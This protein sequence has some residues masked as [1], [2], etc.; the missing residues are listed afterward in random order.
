MEGKAKQRLIVV[1]NRLPF[2]LLEKNKEI[3]LKESDGGLVSAL[4][5]YFDRPERNDTFDSKWWIGSADFPEA[6]W[7]KFVKQS[8][9][10]VSFNVE[11]IFIE[12]KIFNKF[13]NGFCNAT[14]WP[15]F[16]YVPSFVE[17]DEETFK[18]YEAVNRIFADKLLSFLQPNDILWIHD[19]QLMLLPGMIR[20]QRPDATIGFFLHIPF[21]SFEVF[22]MLHRPWK[23]KIV[24]G[25]L[26]ADM[27]GFHTHEYVQHFLKTV[28][29]HFSSRQ[30]CEGGP[31]PAGNRL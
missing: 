19:Y 16:H 28:P 31:V 14:L 12:K 18:S 2:Q 15:L 13:Y 4:K 11:P 8:K 21:P 7:N 20:E 5:S 24:N 6:R 23:E 30:T 25:L 27:I 9:A 3:V 22:R 1:S 17:F 29:N 26:G 10:P